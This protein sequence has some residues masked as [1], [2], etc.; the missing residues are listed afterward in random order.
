MKTNYTLLVILSLFIVSCAPSRF[1]KPLN[2]KQHAASI[3]LG[4]PLIQYGNYTIPVPFLA[5]NYGY[6]IDSTL[7]GFAGMNVT[8][9]LFG[10]AQLELGITKQLLK[11]HTYL[12]AISVTPQLNSIYRDRNSYKFYPQLDLN[13]F[14]EYGKRKNYFYVGI[15]NWFELSKTRT[16]GE[17]QPNHIIFMPIAGHTFTTKKWNFNL[18]VKVIAPNLSNDNIVV[19]YKTPLKSKGAFGLYFGVTRRFK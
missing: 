3:S 6:G 7:T 16:L 1:I 2:K 9:A 13:A 18:E 12:P 15:S 17:S 10:N 19:D 4:G 8:S 14:W 5:A 11:Q